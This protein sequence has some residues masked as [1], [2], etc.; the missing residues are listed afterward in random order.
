MRRACQ[1]V[2][3]S[4]GLQFSFPPV[5]YEN[6][7]FST[8]LE[9]SGAKHHFIHICGNNAEVWNVKYVNVETLKM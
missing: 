5:R 6:F 7:S 4:W 8:S 9:I 2:S 1:T 3:Q